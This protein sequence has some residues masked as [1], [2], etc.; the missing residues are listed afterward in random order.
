MDNIDHNTSSSTSSKSFHGTAVSITQHPENDV[1]YEK[2]FTPNITKAVPQT[3]QELPAFYTIVPRIRQ[4][5]KEPVPHAPLGLEKFKASSMALLVEEEKK[6]LDHISSTL[7]NSH[8]RSWSAFQ[9]EVSKD[10]ILIPPPSITGILPLFHHSTTD[11]S[12]VLHAMRTIKSSIEHLNPGQTPVV[13]GDQPVF[14]VLKQLQWKYSDELGEDNFFVMFG[15]LHLEKQSLI[16]IANLLKDSGWLEVMNS[17]GIFGANGAAAILHVA[18]IKKARRAHEL[19]L[20]CLHILRVK[21][22]SEQSEF[23]DISEWH[24][25]KL[26][27]SPQYKYWSLVMQLQENV[28]GLIRSFRTRNWKL[29]VKCIKKIV[30]W[31]FVFNHPNYARWVSIHIR[32]I[33]MLETTQSLQDVAQ[34][35]AKGKFCAVKGKRN[36]SAIALDH[37]HEQINALI[38][39]NEVPLG[40]LIMPQH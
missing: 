17:A 19:C 10:Q 33:E 20:A 21:A 1:S 34:E 5:I 37:N 8:M 32:D 4:E 28:L 39:G 18:H 6:W 16:V 7:G 25:H 3:L 38:K 35:F 29:Y 12:M 22:F 14:Q 30:I 23:S 31:F 13:T 40:H 27:V 36:F 9:A 24:C 11:P 2:L 15:G 26:K